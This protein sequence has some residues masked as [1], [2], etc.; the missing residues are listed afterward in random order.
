MKKWNDEKIEIEI[1][2]VMKRLDINYFPT[3]REIDGVIGNTSLTNAIVSSH[4]FRIWAMKLGLQNKNSN[5][6]KGNTWEYRIMDILQDKGYRVQKMSYKH[7]Y[8]ILINSNIKIDVKVSREYANHNSTL[9]TFDLGHKEHN[10][11][12]FICIALD[13]RDQIHKLFIIPS[14]VVMGQ[15]QIV[16]GKSSKYDMFN[17]RLDVIEK[18]DEFYKKI[19]KEYTIGR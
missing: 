5:C 3:K 19:I 13:K 15:K 14:S 6:K 11:D 18:Y 4:G 10:C 9:H 7:H 17:Y 8:D 16:V 12:I 1:R 2:E